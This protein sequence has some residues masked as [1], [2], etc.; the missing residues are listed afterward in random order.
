[1]VKVPRASL[2][3]NS[4]RCTCLPAL[5]EGM[6]GEESTAVPSEGSSTSSSEIPNAALVEAAGAVTEPG[7]KGNGVGGT[8]VDL[9]KGIAFETPKPKDVATRE[10]DEEGS[11]AKKVTVPRF[12][13][14]SVHPRARCFLR[15]SG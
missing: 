9:A 6:N 15:S 1:M 4:R 7:G 13:V 10:D 2:P 12:F 5:D 11:E 14:V 8:A 3:H